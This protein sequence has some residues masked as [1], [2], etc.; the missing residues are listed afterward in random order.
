MLK[1]FSRRW[2][3]LNYAVSEPSQWTTKAI[4]EDLDEPFKYI[5]EA[6][7]TL[8]KKGLVVLGEKVGRSRV[9]LPTP[10]GVEV[11]QRSIGK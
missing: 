5:N 9:L 3:V 8:T 10:A 6:R 7:N 11:F 4:A 1:P 2:A